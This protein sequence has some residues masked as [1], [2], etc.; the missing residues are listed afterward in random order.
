MDLLWPRLLLLLAIIPLMVAAYVWM[1]SRKRVA[2]RYSS[3]ALVR[4]AL[5][6]HAGL[7]RHVPFG[8]MM[9]CFASLIFAIGR[10]VNVVSV[11]ANQTTVIL[12]LDVSGSMCQTDIQPSR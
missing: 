7:R 3:L 6:P 1:L 9:A 12:A 10:P 4:D 2:V 5:P 11:P 8:L